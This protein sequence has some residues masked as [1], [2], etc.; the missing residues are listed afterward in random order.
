M[1]TSNMSKAPRHLLLA[2]L[3]ALPFALGALPA[4]A[5]AVPVGKP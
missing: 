2:S 4:G 1:R 5:T 3:G